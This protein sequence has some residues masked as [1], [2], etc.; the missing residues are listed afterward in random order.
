MQPTVSV[1]IGTLQGGSLQCVSAY[2]QIVHSFDLAFHPSVTRSRFPNVVFHEGNSHKLLPQ[3]LSELA[4]DDTNVDFALVDGDHSAEGVKKDLEDLLES[5]SVR[6]TIILVHDTL[7]E[8]VRAGLRSVDFERDKVSKVELDF[9][10]GQV[11]GGETFDHDFWGGLGLVATGWRIERGSPR[12]TQ[13]IYDAVDVFS[14][15]RQ[16]L[17]GGAEV[18]RPRYGEI[19][20]LERQLADARASMRLMERSLS[21]RITAPLRRARSVIRR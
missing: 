18:E 21:W 13:P 9:V 12:T 1:E 3:V 16:T 8:R 6:Q 14:T 4:A 15:F 10:V 17:E 20:A 5:P 11:W 7:N 2:S 19:N